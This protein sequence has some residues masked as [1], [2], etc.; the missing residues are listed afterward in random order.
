MDID[1]WGTK[2]IRRRTQGT[3]RMSYMKTLSRRF[4]NGFRQGT[5]AKPKAI[6]N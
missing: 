1:N 3:G 6:A 2:A 5:Q 4:K